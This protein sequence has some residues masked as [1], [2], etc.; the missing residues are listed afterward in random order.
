MYSVIAL[1]EVRVPREFK[2][3]RGAQ[4]AAVRLCR[5]WESMV[6]V[7][8]SNAMEVGVA[9][10]RYATWSPIPPF[11]SLFGDGVVYAKFYLTPQELLA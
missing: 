6:T 5:K 7:L 8:D 4:I 10:F 9:E 3:F 1:E 2:T 11:K